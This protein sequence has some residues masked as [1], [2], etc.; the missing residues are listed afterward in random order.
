MI[1]QALAAL[2]AN[3]VR[4][5]LTMLGVVIGIF[6]VITLVTIGEGAKL[7]VTD[8][9]QSIGAGYNS[10]I[11]AAGR[12]ATTP[13]NPKFLYSDI[14]Y[15]KSRIPEIDDIVPF[16]PGSGDVYY[17]KKKYES[18]VILGTTANI[19]R[20]M[21]RGVKDGRFFTEAE[22]EGRKK[23]AVLGPKVARE[24]FGEMSPLGEK[25]KIRGNKYL[26]VG[27]SQSL[28]SIGPV[29]MDSR[30]VVPVTSAQNMMGTNYIMRMNIFP[31]DV[32]KMEETQE[33][34]RLALIKRLH[35][36]DFRFVTQKGLLDIVTNILTALTGFVSGIA[37]ISL[38]VG[39]VGIMNIMLVAVN[40]RVREIGIRKAIGAKK[41][42][43]ILQFLIESM[44]ISLI[45]GMLGIFFG[46]LGAF[47]IMWFIKGTLVIAVWAVVLATSVSAAVGIFFGVYPAI[48]A[49]SLDPVIALRYE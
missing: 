7:Y 4:S 19:V 25:I 22:V 10:F 17:G 18:P 2:L 39:G 40:E 48:R 28:G 38:L 5:L 12:D 46:L 20:L 31:K 47:L 32:K 8:Q 11:V 37:A 6:S 21:D 42:D 30:V 33:K 34:V 43:I 29:D 16:T 9:I 24:L 14:A 23:V 36:D 26:I 3:K 15:L 41:K 44:L 27:V 35:D 49:A 45:G 13:P 1:R